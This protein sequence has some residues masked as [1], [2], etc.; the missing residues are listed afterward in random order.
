LDD[1]PKIE[2][3]SFTTDLAS[4]L[5]GTFNVKA[6]PFNAKGDGLADDTAAIMA[7]LA[8]GAAYLPPGT[9]KCNVTVGN[10]QSLIG[11]G[12]QNTFL[13][14]FDTTQPVV[15]VGDG[16]T[17][18]RH[19]RLYGFTIG[20]KTG[21]FT[22]PAGLH[23]NGCYWL[24]V[25]H[26]DITSCTGDNLV[27]TSSATRPVSYARFRNVLSRWARGAGLRIDG[28]AG[29]WV[30]AVF[31]NGL[32]IQGYNDPGSAAIQIRDALIHMANAW[33]QAYG[34]H[35]IMI[36]D[37]ASVIICSNV[38][39]DSDNSNDVLVEYQ[40]SYGAG[41]DHPAAALVGS[42]SVDGM[43]KF[44]DGT[45]LPD[46]SYNRQFCDGVRLSAASV[47]GKLQFMDA[48]GALTPAQAA[49]VDE[50]VSV[51]RFGSDL[52]AQAPSSVRVQAPNI[53]IRPGTAGSQPTVR[54]TEEAP[55]GVQQIYAWQGNMYLIPLSGGHIRAE[56]PVKIQNGGVIYSG[57]GSP[58]GV[59][60]APVGS[61]YL[62]TN[63]GAGSTL[64]VKESG[65]GIN[66]GW[67]AK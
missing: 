29:S 67:V 46:N 66:T 19:V 12:E 15:S 30:S 13:L 59:I 1:T 63:G 5:P 51:Y 6:P 35:G 49:T 54:L 20:A 18:T 26:V 45:T 2:L 31:F 14:P 56:A 10:K 36:E 55:Y 47:R 61:M 24:D 34:N 39:V 11:A 62:R 64:Y 38:V 37:T 9:Y 25:E 44:P 3:G 22:A 48:D 7:A 65:D 8:K 27:I 4:I 40:Q 60:A 57:N 23:I 52:Y 42:V 43:F 16:V 41:K 50:A 28:S 17:D 33:V 58:E 21:S 53:N 32:D